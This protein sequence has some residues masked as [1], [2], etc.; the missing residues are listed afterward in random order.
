MRITGRS[1]TFIVA[2]Q[3]NARLWRISLSYSAILAIFFFAAVGLAA[4]G[5]A[6]YHY[7]RMVLGEKNFNRL[8][9]ENDSFRAENHG[10]RTQTARLGEKIGFLETLA[11]R[12][13]I[14]SGMDTEG[15]VGG[16]GGIS[17]GSFSQPLPA[18]G[19]TISSF[20]R[21]DIVVRILE[22]RFRGMSQYFSNKA[23]LASG[24]PDRM[25]VRG[26]V[27]GTMGPREDPF[28]ASHTEDHSGLDIAAP[29]GS[30]VRAPADG[31]VIFRGTREDYGNIV[32]IDHKFGIVTRF[33][34]L[35]RMTVTVGQKISR[36]DV[37]GFVGIT[38]RTT[39]PHLHYEVWQHNVRMDPEK[40]F[41]H[42][43]TD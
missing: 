21:Y 19:S 11:H 4:V 38:G 35:S 20:N 17:P 26:Y 24:M 5:A 34:H 7:G 12:L 37:I 1:Y 27:S 31:V 15:S 18:A 9:A 23:L 22:D 3:A 13:S 43:A 29:Y 36:S 40:F 10:F 6:A 8:Q 32:V 14:I 39:G 28:N 2:G 41:S 30:P 33:G 16:I 25:P 42:S